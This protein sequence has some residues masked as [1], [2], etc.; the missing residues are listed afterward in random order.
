MK[1]P[2]RIALLCWAFP[3]VSGLSIFGL[4]LFTAEPIWMLAGM[5][6]M[7]LGCLF[8]LVGLIALISRPCKTLQTP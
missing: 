4:W 8:F 2:L 5:G 6:A 1:N 7:I 3:L